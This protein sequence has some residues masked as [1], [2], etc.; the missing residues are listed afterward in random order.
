[1]LVTITGGSVITIASG[2]SSGTVSVAAPTD[3]VYVDAGT[4][5]AVITGTSGSASGNF[6]SLVA[7]TVAAV[8]SVTDDSDVTTV[9]LSADSS[10]EEGGYITYTASLSSAAQ[11][12]WH[13]RHG[14]IGAM[15][16]QSSRKGIVVDDGRQGIGIGWHR[17][18]WRDSQEGSRHRIEAATCSR[19][20]LAA[21]QWLAIERRD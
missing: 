14:L 11:G 18:G 3:D 7:S 9:S 1:M 20:W 21:R 2:S 6:E 8:T 19:A 12:R 13:C 10:V 15:G 5:S 17:T 16:L 4:V